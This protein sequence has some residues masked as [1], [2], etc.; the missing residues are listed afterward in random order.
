MFGRYTLTIVKGTPQE[1]RD[2]SSSLDAQRPPPRHVHRRQSSTA[3]VASV[4]LSEAEAGIES[5]VKRHVDS[6]QLLSRAGGEISFRLPKADA[7]K[8]VEPESSEA[9]S[10]SRTT[11]PCKMTG[12][13]PAFTQA[14]D[15][16]WSTPHGFRLVKCTEVLQSQACACP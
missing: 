14:F 11:I 13:A 15:S 2:S 9:K 10:S 8:C 5:L 1:S 3:S 6:A 12:G 4:A 16:A 7:S